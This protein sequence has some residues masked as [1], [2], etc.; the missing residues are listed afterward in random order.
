MKYLKEF[1]MNR[2]TE[3]I[4]PSKSISGVV[5]DEYA[6]FWK[7]PTKM[8]NLEIALQKIGMPSDDII[9]N[10][11]D[12]IHHSG[13]SYILFLTDELKRDWT[14]EDISSIEKS[15]FPKNMI[16]MGVVDVEEYEVDAYEYNI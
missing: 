6:Y 4:I 10:F 5:N 3:N 11:C 8:P 16:F 1:D 7:V 9:K 2:I 14:W 12:N 13:K 15:Y